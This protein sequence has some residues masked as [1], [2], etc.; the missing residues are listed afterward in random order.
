MLEIVLEPDGSAYE[1]LIQLALEQCATFSLVMQPGTRSSSLAHDRL[2]DLAPWLIGELKVHEWPGTK[3]FGGSATLYRFRAEKSAVP[4]LS[5]AQR[6]YA[7][8]APDRPEDL[9]F[10]NE[11]GSVWLASAHE[12]FAYLDAVSL[13]ELQIAHRIPGLYL[14]R[15][16]RPVDL[17]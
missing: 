1:G 3:L 8:L 17:S 14:R 2:G 11:D 9:A 16:S 4:I 5:E 10:Y 7:W 6:L 13:N 15:R 12:R